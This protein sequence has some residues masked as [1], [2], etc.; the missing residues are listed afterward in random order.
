M[1]CGVGKSGSPAPNP[2]TGRPAALSALAFAS[3]ASVADSL[4]PPILAETLR[5]DWLVTWAVSGETMGQSSQKP[6]TGFPPTRGIRLNATPPRPA[7]RCGWSSDAPLP[8]T[9]KLG[10]SERQPH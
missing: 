10:T 6:P 8:Y 2:I 7:D 4:I 1:D 9:S 5:A 3:T